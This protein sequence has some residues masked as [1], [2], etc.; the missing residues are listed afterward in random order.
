MNLP[1]YI[2][3]GICLECRQCC[4]FLTVDDDWR[5]RTLAAERQDADIAPVCGG[6][7]Y[8]LTTSNGQ[9]HNC[10]FLIEENNH[11]VVYRKRPFEC[12]LYPFVLRRQEGR[13]FVAAHL[14]C[15]YMQE[16]F[17]TDVYNAYVGKLR[18]V[19]TAR[20]TIDLLVGELDKVGGYVG[21]EP[22]LTNLFVLPLH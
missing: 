1:N 20:E 19:F 13:T 11:C 2:P 4:R 12:S 5:P 8:V 6:D 14:G 22:E 10:K 17:G 21:Y 3:D 9:V 18:D 16:T 15:P 7:G